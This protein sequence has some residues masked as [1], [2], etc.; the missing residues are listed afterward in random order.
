MKITKKRARIALFCSAAS[1]IAATPA[2]AQEATPA[3]TE[4]PADED[5]FSADGDIVVTAQ[6]REERL[7]DVP[8]SVSAVSEA[9]IERAGVT[10]VANIGSLVPNIQINQTVG[11]TFGPLISIRGLAPSADTSLGRDQPVDFAIGTPSI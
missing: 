2:L 8:I 7:V 6:R 5:A 9:M 3:G 4:T 11:N 1:L 10:S